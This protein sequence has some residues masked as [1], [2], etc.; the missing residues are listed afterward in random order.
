MTY[1]SWFSFKSFSQKS[2]GISID[3]SS[4]CAADDIT[5]HETK[6][7]IDPKSVLED[8][9]DIIIAEKYLPHI[10]GGIATWL[11]S[12]EDK[13]LAVITQQGKIQYILNKEIPIKKHYQWK[14]EWIFSQ[15]FCTRK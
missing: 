10:S 1:S 2:L 13:A 14:Y 9:T 15:V 8:L 4:V 5:S 6:F 7:W 11:L 12:Y 3:R